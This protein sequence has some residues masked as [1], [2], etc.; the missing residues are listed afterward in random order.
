MCHCIHP[1]CC[2]RNV[3]PCACLS[4]KNL[5]SGCRLHSTADLA[6]VPCVLLCQGNLC[7]K[8]IS[9]VWQTLSRQ[10]LFLKGFH[11]SGRLCQGNLCFKKGFHL[12]GRLDDGFF[13]GNAEHGSGRALG[14]GPRESNLGMMRAATQ[15]SQRTSDASVVTF[16]DLPLGTSAAGRSQASVCVGLLL[17]V[18]GFSE[19]VRA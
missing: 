3:S 2:V 12:F 7:L 10:F 1:R 8:R 16:A 19:R 18:H 9:F 11:L 13:Y 4:L 6:N 15:R 14:T 5:R 17:C